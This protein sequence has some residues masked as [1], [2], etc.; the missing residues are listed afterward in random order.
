MP[1]DHVEINAS[2]F[3]RTLPM[4]SA[5]FVS[6]RGVYEFFFV[7]YKQ[8]WSGFDQ[9]ITG[10][11]DYKT[12]YMYS[13]KNK[14]LENCPNFSIQDFIKFINPKADKDIH[15][16]PK[17][18]G[19]F[20]MLDLLGYGKYSNSSG[21]AYTDIPEKTTKDLG[22]VT[23]FRALAYQKIYSDHYR[24]STYED[25][26]IESF[27][28]DFFGQSGKMKAVVSNEPWDYD[29]FTM[30]YRNAGKD[31]YT[32]LRP[33]PL[34]SVENFG[35]GLAPG[36][37]GVSVAS[38][39]FNTEIDITNNAGS[40]NLSVNDIRNAFALDKLASITMRA[41]KTYKE[42]I[43]AHFGISVDEG[44]DGKCEY[45]GGFDSNMQ[46]GDVTQ[47]SG[48][49]VTGTKDTKFGGYLGRTTGK[50]TGSGNG[51]IKYDAREHGILMC[52]YSVV[53]DVQYDA[54]KI[55]PFVQKI[56]RGDFFIPEFEDLGMQPLFC[57]NISWKYAQGNLNSPTG[58]KSPAFGWQPRYSEYKTA[59]DTNHGQFANG[60]PLSFWSI[61]RARANDFLHTFNISSLK[62]NPHWLDSVFAVDYNGTELTDQF[63]GECY[64]NILKVS[65]MTVD[66]MPRV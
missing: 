38:D 47:T 32:N 20:R 12:S 26:Q 14:V 64:F 34:F 1:H 37:L 53:P 18:N 11:S 61:G 19:V 5:A 3:M 42:Q 66:G 46:V 55:D 29:W 24:N 51:Q 7:P 62:I 65:D 35:N 10:M 56:Q 21:T 43:E 44:R 30:R 60:E 16:F 52:I 40:L 27:N 49:T 28:A 9:F 17:K 23:P 41:G 4:N 58:S 36:S 48:T 31:I 59:L 39:K 57:K 54:T 22:N 13:F 2:D 6:M 15:G 33:T 8:L 63:Y 45:L 25:F 50:A